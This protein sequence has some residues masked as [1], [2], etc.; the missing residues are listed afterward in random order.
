M[1]LEL[2]PWSEVLIL[3]EL[4]LLE[5]CG[6][7]ASADWAGS[8]GLE[9]LVDT[10]AVELMAA[11]EDPDHLPGLEVRHADHADSLLGVLARLLTRVPVA[12]QLLD[13]TLGQTLRLDLAKPLC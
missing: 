9:P 11:W 5:E 8:V 1:C 4:G 6:S 7:I 3:F 12:G 10:L 2:D 13:V